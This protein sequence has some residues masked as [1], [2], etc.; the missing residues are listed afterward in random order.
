MQGKK[1]NKKKGIKE[2]WVGLLFV[3]PALIYMLILSGWPIIYNIYLSFKDVSIYNLANPAAR[4]FI[5][6][7][8]YKM[9]FND[10]A[11][12]PALTNTLKYTVFSLL[13]QFSLGLLFALLFNKK[14]ALSNFLR[15]FMLISWMMPVTVTGLL[16][17]YL[18]SPDVG[19]INT[20][21]Q[22]I[23]L[24]SEPIKWLQD[25]KTALW[26]VIITNTWIGVPFNMLLLYT[27]L[28]TISAELYESASIDGANAFQRF[29]HITLPL[30][31]PAILS[32]LV[33][34]FVYTFKVFE[35]IYVMTGG[36]PIY[37]TEVLATFAYK[38]S[39]A[40]YYFGQ[41]AAVANIL[42]LI[43][44]FVSL[45]YLRLIKNEESD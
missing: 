3:M 9:I 24:I 17:Q 45:I 27:G 1:L 14:F 25:T 38:K 23:G 29:L 13:F 30:L 16:F 33:L 35:L 18:L 39:F 4:K 28:S 37:A 19:A 26:G 41:G 43:L 40:Y 31:K 42:L 8:N 5:G 7:G 34:G 32:V 21:L 11:M 44:M 2:K 20:F 10:E 12:I 15:G 6:F 36:G 22:N